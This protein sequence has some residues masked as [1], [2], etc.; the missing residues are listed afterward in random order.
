MEFREF[1]IHK[2]DIKRCVMDNQLRAT[3]IVEKLI[4]NIG[5]RGF[6]KQEFIGDS[7]YAKRFPGPPADPGFQ[8][9]GKYFGQWRT[10]TSTAPDLNDLVAFVVGAPIWFIPV[11]SYRGPLVVIPVLITVIYVRL[12]V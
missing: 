7:V 8:V 11:V 2:A 12:I 9:N 10:T 6:I 5:E 3:D 4:G 1:V